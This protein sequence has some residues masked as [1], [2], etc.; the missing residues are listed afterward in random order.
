MAGHF[1]CGKNDK[2]NHEKN[3]VDNRGANSVHDRR[4]ASFCSPHQGGLNV[5][6]ITRSRNIPIQGNPDILDLD[7]EQENV[8][9]IGCD[10]NPFERP[11][12]AYIE[13]D[14]SRCNSKFDGR[15]N[16]LGRKLSL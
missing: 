14:N 16:N 4:G 6:T 9:T 2:R 15:D 7:Q 13:N 1:Q 12:K 3:N 5:V 8:E 11:E 10:A